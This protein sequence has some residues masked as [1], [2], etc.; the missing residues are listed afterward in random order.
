MSY[1]MWAKLEGNHVPATSKFSERI[2]QYLAPSSRVLDLGCGYGR[3]SGF[4]ASKGFEVYG[5]DLNESAIEEAKRNEKL[6]G[7]KF[8]IQDA[9]NT[10][11][12]NDFFEGISSQ[13]VLACMNPCD[14]KKMLEESYRILK[15]KGV[16]Q[17]AEF[18]QT[19]NSDKYL[20]HEKITGEYGTTIVRDSEGLEKF[21][22]HNF[23]KVEL[24]ELILNAR[25]HILGY[26]NL[27]FITVHG[28]KHPGHIFLCQKI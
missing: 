15:P 10:N 25:L 14:R 23:K 13:A 11:F 21:R 3:L 2:L 4:F 18:G 16:I 22:S 24:E 9:T 28:N 7:I 12:S 6:K 19:D 26:E 5:I 20:E 17:I 27:D 8:S 1:K